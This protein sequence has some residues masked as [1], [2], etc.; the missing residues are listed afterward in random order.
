M[1]EEEKSVAKVAEAERTIREET[2]RYEQVVSK[3]AT[4]T[5]KNKSGISGKG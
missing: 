5:C 3:E 1:V 2:K 4:V